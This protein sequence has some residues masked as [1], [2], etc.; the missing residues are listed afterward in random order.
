MIRFSRALGA[1]AFAAALTG[2]APLARAEALPAEPAGFTLELALAT[3]IRHNPDIQAA[4][5]KLRQAQIEKETEDLWWART[6]RGQANYAP[7]GGGVGGMGGAVTA[8]GTAIPAAAVGVGFNLGELLAGPKRSASAQ[9]GIVIAQADL[10][11]TTLAVASQVTAAYQAYQS[12]KQLAATSGD[13]VAAAEADLRTAERQFGRG[14]SAAGAL[15]GARLAVQRVRVDRIQN[16]ST[17]ASAWMA[18]IAAMGAPG[19]DPDGAAKLRGEARH[20]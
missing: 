3:A 9:Q 13:M 10:R 7:F 8:D 18:L 16:H 17:V 11:R 19:P 2:F 4:E 6:L 1:L 15:L 12:A 14:E 20:D 5:A